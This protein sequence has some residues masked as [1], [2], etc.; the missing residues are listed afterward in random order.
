MPR[1]FYEDI[2]GAKGGKC[3]FNR[4][5]WARPRTFYEDIEGAKEGPVGKC[6]FSR[7]RWTRAAK[8]VKRQGQ[9]HLMKM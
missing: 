5:R 1:T 6:A 7:W 2:E 4:W 8:A 9:E 3:T